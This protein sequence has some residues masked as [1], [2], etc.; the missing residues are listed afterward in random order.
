MEAENVLA[1][2][3]A[4]NSRWKPREVLQPSPRVSSCE[5]DPKVVVG[6][7]IEAKVAPAE[8]FDDEDAVDGV[9]LR[10]GGR[11]K[12]LCP[13]TTLKIPTPPPPC[14]FPI[15]PDRPDMKVDSPMGLKQQVCGKACTC[16]FQSLSQANGKISSGQKFTFQ[17]NQHRGRDGNGGPERAPPPPPPHRGPGR[18]CNWPSPSV[19][20]EID[21]DDP[22]T[23]KSLPLRTEI[24]S[25]A[26]LGSRRTKSSKKRFAGRCFSFGFADE[27]GDSELYS[28]TVSG[29]PSSPS[30]PG[31]GKW[32]E[33][34]VDSW[35]VASVGKRGEFPGAI[36]PSTMSKAGRRYKSASRH[37]IP[38]EC[39]QV[40]AFGT[41]EGAQVQAEDPGR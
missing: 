39:E 11:N 4:Q 36:T 25:R 2:S 1:A 37:R 8:N 7:A 38:N 35:S 32:I 24:C 9:F 14:P 19:S 31:K 23:S 40:V 18:C 13:S 26:P 21:P 16:D 28:V 30:P 3:G 27:V 33:A 10:N 17:M 15:L 5:S 6:E 20:F 41:S 34:V 29:S 12:S 22:E